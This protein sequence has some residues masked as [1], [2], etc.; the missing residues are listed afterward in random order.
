MNYT[1]EEMLVLMGQ[2]SDSLT[3][4]NFR[5]DWVDP[6]MRAQNELERRECI[7]QLERLAASISQKN[8]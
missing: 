4:F 3:F 2:L 8:G 7:G 6:S 5:Q 1:V